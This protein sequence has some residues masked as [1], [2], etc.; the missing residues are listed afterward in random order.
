MSSS[1]KFKKIWGTK[2]EGQENKVLYTHV[3]PS[4]SM[5]IPVFKTLLNKKDPYYPS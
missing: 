5:T 3:E 4:R 2:I 1:L